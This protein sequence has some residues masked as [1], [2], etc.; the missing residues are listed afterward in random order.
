[1]TE[2]QAQLEQE[3]AAAILTTVERTEHGMRLRAQYGKDEQLLRE[4]EALDRSYAESDKFHA[5]KQDQ[6]YR[7][8]AKAAHGSEGLIEIDADAKISRGDGGAYV[9][10]WIWVPSDDD[11]EEKR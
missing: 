4:S 1:M 11:E 10:A 7:D 9:A 8:A 5:E 2:K 6:A 3:Q